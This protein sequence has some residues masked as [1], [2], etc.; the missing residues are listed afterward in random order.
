VNAPAFPG[1]L[2][3]I[4]DLQR[5]RWL[6]VRSTIGVAYLVSYR[7][8]PPAPVPQGVVEA[9][10]EHSDGYVMTRFDDGLVV[11]QRVRLLSGAFA[12]FIG[13]LERLDGAGRV[14]VLLEMMGTTVPV[15]IHRSALSPAA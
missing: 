9:L 10:T 14:Q 8:G 13:S 5:D 7:D 12:N 6:S 15:E 1:Y 2:F 11:G 4:L 3:V